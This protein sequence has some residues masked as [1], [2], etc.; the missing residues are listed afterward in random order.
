VWALTKY[1][2]ISALVVDAFQAQ[3]TYLFDASLSRKHGGRTTSC[4]GE[5]DW[6]NSFGNHPFLF[7]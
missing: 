4:F 2:R 5:M 3:R 1:E 7:F 6:L